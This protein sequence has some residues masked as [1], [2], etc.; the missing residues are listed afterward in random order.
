[1]N[2]ERVVAVEWA[3]MQGQRP[4]SAGSNGRLGD[5][6]V[7]VTP[8]IARLTTESGVRGFGFSRAA[9][10]QAAKVVGRPLGDLFSV[11]HGSSDVGRP[12]DFALWDLAGQLAA[13]PVYRL[14]ASG[15]GAFDVEPVRVPC[16]D[17]SLYI[18]DL[19]LSSDSEAAALIAGEAIDGYAQGH[20]AFKIKVGRGARHMPLEEGVRRDI[21][22]I[23]A[24]RESVGDKA[25]IMLDANNG[26]NLN[27]TKQILMETAACRIHWME[28]AFHEDRIL[29]ED[30]K[31]WISVSGLKT[32]IADG[33]GEASPS[34][35][36]WAE[37]G[38][39][40]VVQYDIFSYGF[41][42]WLALGRQ[43]DAWSVQSAPHHYGGFYGNY[44]VP[45]LASAINGF[46]YAEWDEAVVPG[47]DTSAYEIREGFV[48]LPNE[49]GFGLLLDSDLFDQAV[50]ANGY[51][52]FE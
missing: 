41:S 40:D 26:Y 34:L 36:D 47:I 19:H 21:A 46:A 32:L 5:H 14:A 44:A 31:E 23:H 18:D 38:L 27:L 45:H 7:V 52:I 37:S 2:K 43:L 10:Q 48:H 30:L 51:Q 35:L 20:R 25:A 16:Y 29:Y 4:R 39:V 22:V 33:E 3:P 28:E 12:F 17:T 13:Q 42:R 9:A 1:M 11:E 6:G 15:A 8:A 49:P 24:V 50:C